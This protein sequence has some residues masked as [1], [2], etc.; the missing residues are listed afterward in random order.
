MSRSPLHHSS[1]DPCS[2]SSK[3]NNLESLQ[4]LDENAD[5]KDA[6]GNP[7]DARKSRESENERNKWST[8][9]GR[10]VNIWLPFPMKQQL[11]MAVFSKTRR[12][13]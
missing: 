3:R 13:V 8:A 9:T 10:L 11:I 4:L 7:P 5:S 6:V 2:H 1:A 12:N